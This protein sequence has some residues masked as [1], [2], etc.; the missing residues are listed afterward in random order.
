MSHAPH[1]HVNPTTHHTPQASGAVSYAI[2]A[3]GDGVLPLTAQ[4]P[5][6]VDPSRVTFAVGD[7]LAL[8]SELGGR[9]VFFHMCMGRAARARGALCV[10]GLLSS[11]GK[12]RRVQT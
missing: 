4:L 9:C 10:W 12:Y 1:T 2:K 3:E 5:T 6:G 8:P 11:A 7:A